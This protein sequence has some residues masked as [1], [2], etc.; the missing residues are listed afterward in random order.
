MFITSNDR[1][2]G[3]SGEPAVHHKYYV[4]PG[5]EGVASLALERYRR[6]TFGEIPVEIPG[7]FDDTPPQEGRRRAL[8]AMTNASCGD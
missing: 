3:K 1:A 8:E 5:S 2:T 7:C 4:R 6:L